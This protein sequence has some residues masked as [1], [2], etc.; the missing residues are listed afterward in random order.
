VVLGYCLS[1]SL[2]ETRVL[3]APTAL[4]AQEAKRERETESIGLSRNR[5]TSLLHA[6]PKRTTNP[7]NPIEVKG[8]ESSSSL[9]LLSKSK[10]LVHN[11]TSNSGL[12]AHAV[13]IYSISQD[14]GLS[15]R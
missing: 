7:A 13:K 10:V 14:R 3:T 11:L 12:Y 15:I 2:Y 8:I 9:F 6:G 5:K 4:L 1:G